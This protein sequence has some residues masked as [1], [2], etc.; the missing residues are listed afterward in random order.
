LKA[1]VYALSATT[2][3]VVFG[4]LLGLVGSILPLGVRVGLGSLFAVGAVIIGFTHFSGWR[5]RVAQCDRETPHRWLY[6][7]PFRWALWNGAALGVGV[8]SRIGFWLWYVIPI[9]ATSSGS[10]MIGALIY[11][12]FGFVRGWAVWMVLIAFMRLDDPAVWL[13]QRYQRARLLTAGIL[14]MTGLAATIVLGP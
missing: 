6:G 5:L 10:P 7:S 3:A 9:A 14:V 1:V 2:S 13:I 11:G 8:T 12:S 4:A